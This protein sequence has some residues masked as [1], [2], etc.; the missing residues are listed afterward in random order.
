MSQYQKSQSPQEST[1]AQRGIPK[2]E[3]LHALSELEDDTFKP[4]SLAW[5]I[6]NPCI[7]HCSRDTYHGIPCVSDRP[8]AVGFEF[9]M[10][11]CPTLHLLPRLLAPHP[12]LHFLH[13]SYCPADGSNTSFVASPAQHHNLRK[14]RKCSL[15]SEVFFV[16]EKNNVSGTFLTCIVKR[17]A[18]NKWQTLISHTTPLTKRWTSLKKTQK[19]PTNFTTKTPTSPY[20][21]PGNTHLL[22]F[23]QQKD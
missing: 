13:T 16:I 2:P 22:S 6:S 8:H 3:H 20:H 18:V 11:H 14:N 21:R 4:L 10:H 17:N 9:P 7:C 1:K 15:L 12:H 5:D 19:N 23:R